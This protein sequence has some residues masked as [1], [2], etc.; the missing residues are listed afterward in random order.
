[1]V[2]LLLRADTP[3]RCCARALPFPLAVW[4]SGLVQTILYIDFFWYY[5]QSWK[6]NQKLSLPA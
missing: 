4:I 2:L 6:N 3:T 5:L 1:M